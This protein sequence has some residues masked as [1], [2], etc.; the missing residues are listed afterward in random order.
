METPFSSAK[1]R[2]IATAS[3]DNVKLCRVFIGQSAVTIRFP[4]GRPKLF[5]SVLSLQAPTAAAP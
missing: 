4:F 5:A 1:V 2:K 3:G